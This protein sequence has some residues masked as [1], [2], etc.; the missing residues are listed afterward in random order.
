MHA[1]RGDDAAPLRTNEDDGKRT[2][3]S[4]RLA[5]TRRLRLHQGGNWPCTMVIAKRVRGADMPAT[6][7]PV[8]GQLGHGDSSIYEIR[9]SAFLVQSRHGQGDSAECRREISA[10]REIP[11]ARSRRR[12]DCE[13]HCGAARGVARTTLTGAMRLMGAI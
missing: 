13:A 4:E 1:R 3:R 5:W 8:I 12:G 6:A 7:D 9:S 2:R 11:Q 10:A